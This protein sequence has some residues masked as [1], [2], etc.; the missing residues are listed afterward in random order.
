MLLTVHCLIEN[1]WEFKCLHQQNTL[2]KVYLEVQNHALLLP[3]C[4]PRSWMAISS[5]DHSKKSTASAWF[6]LSIIFGLGVL[7]FCFKKNSGYLSWFNILIIMN[8][9]LINIHLQISMHTCA[10][11]SLWYVPRRRTVRPSNNS[12]LSFRRSFTLL[13]NHLNPHK[14]Y[15][16]LLVCLHPLKLPLKGY[17]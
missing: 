13:F 16:W 3:T 1:R 9:I 12:T 2:W 6:K 11:S 17:N 5:I 14:Q 4:L 8:N 15:T 7:I 10:F